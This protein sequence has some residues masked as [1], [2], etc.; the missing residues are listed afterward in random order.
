MG[1]GYFSAYSTN[2][3][4]LPY[5][6]IAV[7]TGEG[8]DIIY[9]NNIAT[10]TFINGFLTYSTTNP[11]SENVTELQGIPITTASPTNG[12]TL[13]Y[14]AV[15]GDL[16][17]EPVPTGPKGATGS[18]GLTG[19]AGPTGATGP[20]GPTGPTGA[21]GV[22]GTGTPGITVTGPDAYGA[23]AQVGTD[24]TYYARQDHDHGL[25]DVPADIP[26]ASIAAKGDL[27]VGTAAGAVTNLGIGTTGQRPVV[28]S[29]T[30]AWATT[31]I[32]IPFTFAWS[33]A[34]VVAAGATGFIP[35][36][37]FPIPAG[38]T[39]KLVGVFAVLRSGSCVLAVNQ[40]GSA[41]SGLSAL[42]VTTTGA[43]TAATTP[44]A[45]A[46]DDL[47][48]PVVASISGTPDGLSLT[49]IFAVTF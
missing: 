36:M 13:V 15:N 45:V 31:T 6:G 26:L 20:T 22:P 42:T 14:V 47:F 46:N 8:V 4:P 27:I 16:E 48:A 32:S 39:A 5:G 9:T 24:P 41:V 33:G 25:P 17:Y 19:V 18:I 1:L 44:P 7:P 40:K 23:A 34:V 10:Q 2:P 11:G 21:A 29:G 38:Q 35:P 28:A 3:I 30:V 12:E 37:A 43:Y 49:L